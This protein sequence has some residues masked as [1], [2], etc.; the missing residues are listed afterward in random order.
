MIDS[1]TFLYFSE[2]ADIDARTADFDID[3][4][5]S[6]GDLL[7][8]NDAMSGDREIFLLDLCITICGTVIL[9]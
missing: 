7:G 3:V 4:G 9:F 2:N 6:C 8:S 5:E 1:T